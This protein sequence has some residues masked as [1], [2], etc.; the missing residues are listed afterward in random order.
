[1]TKV[2]FFLIYK[3]YSSIIFLIVL[4]YY[5]IIYIEMRGYINEI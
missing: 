2:I 5:A 1:M 3:G 4:I